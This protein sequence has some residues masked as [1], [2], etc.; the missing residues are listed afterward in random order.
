LLI[1]AGSYTHDLKVDEITQKCRSVLRIAASICEANNLNLK[2]ENFTSPAILRQ[3]A[4]FWAQI[5]EHHTKAPYRGLPDLHP[6]GLMDL[7]PRL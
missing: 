4:K 3:L 7:G 2:K 5:N 1:L 6:D